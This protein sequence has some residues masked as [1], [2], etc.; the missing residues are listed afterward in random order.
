MQ[1]NERVLFDSAEKIMELI[2]DEGAKLQSK[3]NKIRVKY[4]SKSERIKKDHA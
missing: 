1:S 2:D 4:E 3:Y